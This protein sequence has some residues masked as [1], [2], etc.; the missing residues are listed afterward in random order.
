MFLSDPPYFLF[1]TGVFLIF[2]LL[3]PG[4][5]RRILLLGA[6]YFFYFQLSKFYILVLF[7]VTALTYFGAIA[8]RSPTQKS[9][10]LLFGLIVALVALPLILFKYT[11]ALLP[12]NLPN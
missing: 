12:T 7:L 4:L 6:S 2:Y 8:L 5:P 11:S 10:N 1:L 3:A 9:P